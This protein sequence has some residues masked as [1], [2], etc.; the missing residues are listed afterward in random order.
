MNKEYIYID[1]KVIVK[2]ENGNQT[3]IEYYDNLDEVLVQENLIETIENQIL[4]LENES[5]KLK[6][7]NKGRYLPKLLLLTALLLLVIMP[8][9]FTYLG[10]IGLVSTSILFGIN[11]GVLTSY[12]LSIVFLPIAALLDF[13]VYSNRKKSIKEEKGIN[14]LL[15]F[16]KNRIV[17]EKENLVKLKQEKSREKENKEFRV[18][19]VNDL[20]MLK[21]FRNNMEL[22]FD[23]GYNGNKYYKYYQQN[24]LDAK[25]DKY[26]NDKGIEIAKKYLEEKG[27]TL[28]K[29]RSQK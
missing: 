20:E 23:L 26:Y 8:A 3:P 4:D 16:L 14:S 19:K 27:P 9:L 24:K 2:D 6:K 22:Y 15:E 12:L 5:Q 7:E 13:T 10:N 18:V 17:I 1:G 11:K 29:R 28:V 21:I 25:L